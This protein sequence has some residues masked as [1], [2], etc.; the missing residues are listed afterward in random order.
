MNRGED[1]KVKVTHQKTEEL[2]ISVSRDEDSCCEEVV[3]SGSKAKKV[4]GKSFAPFI[5]WVVV[6][7]I[8]VII[9]IIWSLYVRD[10]QIWRN[11]GLNPLFASLCWIL[12]FIIVSILLLLLGKWGK[13]GLAWVV[14]IIAIF[15]PILLW[16]FTIYYNGNGYEA[17][18]VAAVS[19]SARA[20]GFVATETVI[21]ETSVSAGAVRGGF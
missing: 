3:H 17:E 4:S 5:I 16:V 11:W 21:E 7:I 9:A 15:L 18:K 19:G 8:F 1:L 10:S 2:D 6:T 14:L 13:T 12:L 20:R